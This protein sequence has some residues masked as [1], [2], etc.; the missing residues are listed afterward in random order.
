VES[1]T[2]RNAMRNLRRSIFDTRAKAAKKN[3]R[4][5]GYLGY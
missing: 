3:P 1:A 5:A 2:V 4:L